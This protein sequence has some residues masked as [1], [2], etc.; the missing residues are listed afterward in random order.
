MRYN[1]ELFCYELVGDLSQGRQAPALLSSAIA[2]THTKH[3]FAT[4][5]HLLPIQSH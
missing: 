1:K 2:G 4:V 5:S 3:G